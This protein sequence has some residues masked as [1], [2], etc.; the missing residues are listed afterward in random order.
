MSQQKLKIP[1]VSGFISIGHG[2]RDLEIRANNGH[3][4][5]NKRLGDCFLNIYPNLLFYFYF[6]N[7]NRIL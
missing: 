5:Y 7:R 1:G 2:Q 4:S 6:M 3:E